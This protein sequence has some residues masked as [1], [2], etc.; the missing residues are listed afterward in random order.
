MN[1][2]QKIFHLF[3]AIIGLTLLSWSGAQAADPVIT[4]PKTTTIG[5]VTGGD[6]GEGLDLQGTFPYAISFGAEPDLDLKIG[7]AV[8]KGQT[9]GDEVPGANLEAGFR[10]LNWYV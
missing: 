3:P 4:N 5:V 7:D 1:K 2:N 6:P 10:I 8:F 9:A